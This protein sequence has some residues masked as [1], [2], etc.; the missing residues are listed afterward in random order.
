M[1]RQK[2]RQ[3]FDLVTDIE[4]TE[5][6]ISLLQTNE[7]TDVHIRINQGSQTIELRIA[8]NDALMLANLLI[9][10]K[11]DTLRDVLNQIF[12]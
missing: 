9:Q 4:N 3:A 6:A 8:R 2:I 1:N 11:E 10:A 5:R 12:Q 7:S